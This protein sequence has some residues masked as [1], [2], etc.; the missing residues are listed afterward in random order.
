VPGY[1]LSVLQPTLG[2]TELLATCAILFACGAL[3]FI[4]VIEQMS[5][6][7]V[8]AGRLRTALQA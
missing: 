3:G 8:M 2:G 7:R 5:R 6:W 4:P 1:Y